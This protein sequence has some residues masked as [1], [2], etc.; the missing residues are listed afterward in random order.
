MEVHAYLAKHELQQKVESALNVAVQA[1]APEPLSVIAAQLLAAAPSVILAV[2]GRQVFDSRGLPTVEAAVTTHRGTYGA[3]VPSGASTGIYEALELRDQDP[4]A[5]GGKGVGRAVAN[6]NEV[7]APALLGL[8]PTQQRRIDELMVQTLDG[9][10]NEHGWA[11]TK[12]GANAILAVSMAVCKAGAAQAQLPLYRHIAAL[13]GNTQLV[14]PVPSFNIING[15]SHAGNKIAFQEFMVMPVGA[16]SFAEAMQIGCEVYH[17]LKTL[18]KAAYGKDAVHV[19]D[20]GGF[21]PPIP[22]VEDGVELIMRAIEACGHTDKCKLALD[23]AA[24]EFFLEA[25]IPSL[26]L[27]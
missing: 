4:A 9:T 25:I 2:V 11:K 3:I 21:A 19:G 22:T 15:G 6:V 7:I 24:S 12:L 10:Q 17:S 18:T 13:A 23:V 14:L 20:E 16:K 8:D 26:R 27:E 1:N 5:F